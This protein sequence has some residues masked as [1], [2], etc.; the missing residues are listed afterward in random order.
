MEE[1][2]KNKEQSC[3]RH[4][5]VNN[6]YGWEMSQKLPVNNVEQIKGT[7]Q[8]SSNRNEKKTEILMNKPICL[9]LSILELIKTLMYE[10]WYDYV[11]PKNGEK[12]KLCFMDTDCVIVYIKIDGLY[13]GIIE[14]VENQ[15]CYFKLRISQSIA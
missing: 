13:K 9:G 1:Y 11:K 2:D 7:S 3:S 6:L 5:D 15:I 8:L 12:A 10:F 4:W 14:D